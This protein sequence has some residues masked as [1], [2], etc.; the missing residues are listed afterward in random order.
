MDQTPLVLSAEQ[1]ETEV[2]KASLGSLEAK[3][4]SKRGRNGKAV[5]E[6][7]IFVSPTEPLE[8]RNI[9]TTSLITE[10]Y[11]SDVLFTCDD[12]RLVGVQR[13][14]FPGDFLASV[15]DGRLAIQMAQMKQLDHG[16]LVLEGRQQWTTEGK[17][18]SNASQGRSRTTW[19]KDQHRGFLYS[20]KH[21]GAWVEESTSLG[22]TIHLVSHLADWFN[23]DQHLS[24]MG[25][26]GPERQSAWGHITNK[27]WQ[28]HMVQGLPNV[29]PTLA[30]NIL[31]DLGMPFKMTVSR[32]ELMTVQGIGKK[33]ADKICKVFETEK[34]V[35]VE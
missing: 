13:K 12:G 34:I 4:K 20:V 24:L 18:V 19:T 27:D 16:V 8:L 7:M 14:Q 17:L 29:G 10:Q 30:G 28:R 25:R 9:G 23:K 32:E 15:F 35:E 11:G 26:P 22:D 3:R 5:R 6:P 33:M 21:M 1:L 2:A 31:R